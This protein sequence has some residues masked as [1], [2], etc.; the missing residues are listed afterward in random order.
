MGSHLFNCVNVSIHKTQSWAWKGFSGSTRKITPLPISKYVPSCCID[1]LHTDHSHLPPLSLQ[2][3]YK[4]ITTVKISII[5]IREFFSA[6]GCAKSGPSWSQKLWNLKPWKYS[7]LTGQGLRK[8]ILVSSFLSKGWTGCLPQVPS[9]LNYSA[10]MRQWNLF[11]TYIFSVWHW[12]RS[13]SRAV[14]KTMLKTTLKTTRNQHASDLPEQQQST[15]QHAVFECVL[16]V[17]A[18]KSL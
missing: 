4:G 15:K 5:Y 14:L 12:R 2:V 3:Y 16:W 13:E 6:W 18:L 8:P 7:D 9:S 10:I 1:A 17:A 11:W